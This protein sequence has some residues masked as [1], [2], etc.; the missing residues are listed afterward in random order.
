[1]LCWSSEGQGKGHCL[2]ACWQAQETGSQAWARAAAAAA[3]EAGCTWGLALEGE[4]RD[5]RWRAGLQWDPAGGTGLHLH[6]WRAGPHWDPG[7]GTGLHLHTWRAGLQWD[8]AGGTGLHLHTWRAGPHWDQARE[9]E[10]QQMMVHLRSDLGK[11]SDSLDQLPDFLTQ[12]PERLGQEKVPECP[13]QAE[14]QWLS[15]CGAADLIYE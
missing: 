8:P 11:G 15:H 9:T 2:S 14:W 12:A 4:P 7:G 6:T 10:I 5:C 1:M 13:D 3:T